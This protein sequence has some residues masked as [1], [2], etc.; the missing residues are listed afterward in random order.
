MTDDLYVTEGLAEYVM[1]LFPEDFI[2]ICVDV[3]AYDP[4]WI[5]NSWIFE[6]KGWDTYCIEPNPNCIP[7]LKE[8]RKNVLEFA[9]ASENSDDAELFIY[10][11]QSAGPNLENKDSWQGEAAGTGLLDHGLHHWPYLAS[12]HKQWQSGVVKVKTRTLDWLMENIIQKDHM[13]YLSI[14][15]E[16]NE[17]AVLKG[18]DLLRWNPKVIAI[19]NLGRELG[20][21]DLWDDVWKDPEEQDVLL[22]SLN[23]RFVHRMTCN[24]IYMQQDYWKEYF[25][26]NE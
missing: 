2:G 24:D 12:S 3:G 7:R 4:F 26:S 11:C 6:Q 15:V 20:T 14:D 10:S 18:V 22:Q 16:R 23:Y 21:P 1:T 19:E 9:C 8:F 5:S 13:D 17:L 25:S